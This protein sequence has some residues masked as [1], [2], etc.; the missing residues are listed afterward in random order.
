MPDPVIPTAASSWTGA[1][2]HAL[3]ASFDRHMVAQFVFDRGRLD[4]PSD[5][6][7]RMSRLSFRPV[8]LTPFA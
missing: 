3:N 2:L 6:Q 7:E 1:S 4:I 5:L 8:L